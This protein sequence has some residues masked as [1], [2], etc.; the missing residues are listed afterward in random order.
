MTVMCLPA[1]VTPEGRQGQTVK[2]LDRLPL[3]GKP[4]TL[5]NIVG[6][7][8]LDAPCD[9]TAPQ[10]PH[11]GPKGPPY[12]LP[13]TV[14][15]PGFVRNRAKP[16]RAAYMRPLQTTHTLPSPVGV[17]LRTTRGGRGGTPPH[18]NP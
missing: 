8:V 15:F 5:P 7:G 12:S 9:P 16:A 1:R 17:G 4:E 14:S 10:T 2:P 18:Q 3:P 11:G 6:G 13:V